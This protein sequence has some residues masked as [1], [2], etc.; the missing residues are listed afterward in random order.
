MRLWQLLHWRDQ[1][2]PGVGRMRPGLQYLVAGFAAGQANESDV[3]DHLI[4]PRDED[5]DFDD[6]RDL[7]MPNAVELVRC[8]AMCPAV[9]QVKDAIVQ[10]ELER[11]ELPTA[12][13]R[14]AGE[15]QSLTGMATLFRLLAALGQKPFARQRLGEG[16]V[17]VLTHLISVTFPAESDTHESFAAQVKQ[18]KLTQERLLQL[19][20][21][22]PQWLA[23]I[24][25]A[26]GWPGL[27]EGVWWFL[28]HTPS[29]HS[30][31]G[32]SEADDDWLDDDDDF[33]DEDEEDGEE[34]E[35]EPMDTRPLD[36][37]SASSRSGPP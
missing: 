9:D 5:D 8:P 24:E 10:I 33:F 28:A 31:L 26:L 19:A 14:P 1:P 7:T 37:W 30:G 29:G 21:L 13:T 32:G 36:P 35:G 20:F 11:G 4:G 15:V 34:G 12:A 3:F 6:L 17:E 25:H 16:R 22:A 27:R 23:H 2:E 18:S